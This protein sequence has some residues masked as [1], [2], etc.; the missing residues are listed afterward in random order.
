M[1]YE[2]II[3]EKPNAAKRIAEAL[4]DKKPVKKSVNK[5]PYYE[6]THN[7]KPIVVTCAVGHLY[8]VA[9]KKKSFTYP[10]FDLHWVPSAD[11]AKSAAFSKKYLNVIKK[12][13]KK[14]NE[15]TVACDYDT[16]G[17]VIGL[18]CIRL[19]CNQKDAKRM[20]FSTLTKE[21][22]IEA[23]DN[24]AKH[25]DQGLGN[26]G[27]ARHFLDWMYGINISRALTLAVKSTGAFRIL[28]SGRVQ[29]PALKI[30]YDKEKEIQAFKSDPYWQ[31]YL[32][33][34]KENVMIEAFH[35]GGKFFKHDEARTKFENSLWKPGKVKS[36]EKNE[37][38]KLPPFPFDLG[39]LQIEAYKLFGINPKETLSLAQNLYTMGVISYPRTS[40][41]KLPEKINYKKIL[42]ALAKSN[43]EYKLK[44]DT[45]LGFKIL[46]PNEGKKSD[47]AHPAIYPTGLK[48]K[49]LSEREAKIYDLIV[50]RFF[51]TFGESAVRETINLKI[52]I[53]SEIFVAQGRRTKEK[54]WFELYE[55]Y[56]RLAEVE[57]PVFIAG[58]DANIKKLEL[59]EKETQPPKRYTPASIINELEKRGLGTKAT[60]AEI[61]DSLYKR[62]YVI[63]QSLKVTDMGMKIIETLQKHC[64]DIIDE[65][66]T[67]HFEEEM[68]KIREKKMKKDEVLD[69]AEK[70]LTKTLKAF[71]KQEKEIGEALKEAH[72]ETLNQ[73]SYVCKCTSCDGNLRVK[74]TKKGKSRIRFIACDNYPECKT[75][76][77]IPQ[78]GGI[79]G[80][81]NRCEHC[82]QPIVMIIMKRRKPQMVCLNK[83]CPGKKVDASTHDIEMETNEKGVEVLKK[84]C[85]KC[86]KDLVIRTS[87]YGKFIGCTSYPKCRHTEKLEQNN[88]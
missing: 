18:N 28:S 65:N 68:Q 88:K 60:R 56:V 3:S 72:H 5:V 85:P 35:E 29:G 79:K 62:K 78:N 22:I 17:E 13:A 67:Q 66:L 15:F 9:E 53:K 30:L 23:Y 25:L 27:E 52:D 14:A 34:K 33:I 69:E 37:T 4:A 42:N 83:E 45:V 74:F 59:L 44:V 51:A 48:A 61:V 80:T 55:P 40:S 84:K 41:Q 81:E 7:K 64:P 12:L 87:V 24:A 39:S 73:E 57:W 31:I 46:K 75:T 21:D 70:L 38:K 1:A 20:K 6:L 26:A 54:N 43:A 50:K 58:E 47:P 10:S 49:E 71:K 16:E 76:F 77:A 86:E 8:T 32:Q 63:E 2:L 19:A 11:V 82:G 36:V